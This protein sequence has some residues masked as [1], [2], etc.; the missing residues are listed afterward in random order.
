M[1]AKKDYR[2]DLPHQEHAGEVHRYRHCFRRG[3]GLEEAVSELEIEPK[4]RN[5]I[6]AM[7]QA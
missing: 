5:R 4:I 1:P 2:A 6:V 7:R 3:G